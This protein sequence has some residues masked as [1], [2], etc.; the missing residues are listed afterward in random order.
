MAIGYN[1]QRPVAFS[2]ASQFA[3]NSAVGWRGFFHLEPPLGPPPPP[4]PPPTWRILSAIFKRAIQKNSFKRF[5]WMIRIQFKLGGGVGGRGGGRN[6]DRFEPAQPG[7]I[8]RNFH[9]SQQTKYA[10]IENIHSTDPI[11]ILIPLPLPSRNHTSILS[12]KYSTPPLH[13]QTNH[14]IWWLIRSHL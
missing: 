12:E 7:N 1:Q 10:G 5:V 13:L 14:L 4:P 11:P 8:S 9:H 2:P 6:V 3:I